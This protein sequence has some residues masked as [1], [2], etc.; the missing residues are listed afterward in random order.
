ML[1]SNKD[2]DKQMSD[3]FQITFDI[4]SSIQDNENL[5]FKN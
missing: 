4:Y 3:N 2:N 5:A 1:I